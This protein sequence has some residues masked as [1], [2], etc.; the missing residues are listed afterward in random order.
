ML[1]LRR[2]FDW[3]Y[4]LFHDIY[5][6]FRRHYAA[7]SLLWLFF[8]IDYLIIVFAFIFAGLA[9]ALF[10]P[11][12]LFLLYFDL[13][14]CF[15][16]FAIFRAII[17]FAEPLITLLLIIFAADWYASMLIFYFF[18]FRYFSAAIFISPL[19]YYLFTPL[20]FSPVAELMLR[21]FSL[22]WYA[23]VLS[24][25][26]SILMRHFLRLFRR[27][28]RFWCC[29]LMHLPRFYASAASS[30]FRATL[31]AM[32]LMLCFR[33]F[34]AWRLPFFSR[35]AYAT[36]WR[37]RVTLFAAYAAAIIILIYIIFCRCAF[38]AMPLIR[39]HCC[40]LS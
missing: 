40:L 5:Y 37:A 38:A 11:P 22:F 25:I 20:L 39:C 7:F 24:L 1:S 28:F 15:F 26:F 8:A 14:W 32:M 10:L 2:L 30:F 31:Y 36:C 4:W 9:F 18:F 13:F 3:L 21:S 33:R 29:R 23:W 35:V 12:W 34:S 6:L 17:S 27:Q 19:I 16:D